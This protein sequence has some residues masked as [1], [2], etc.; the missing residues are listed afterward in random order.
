[1]CV[2]L[3][4]C[5]F[6]LNEKIICVKI[7]KLPFFLQKIITQ[8]NSHRQRNTIISRGNYPLCILADPTKGGKGENKQMR[9]EKLGITDKNIS[10]F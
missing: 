8:T 9:N 6:L 3:D 5:H 1:V 2:S 4:F 7:K 10:H